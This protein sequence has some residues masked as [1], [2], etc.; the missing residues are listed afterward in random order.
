[1]RNKVLVIGAAS[2]IGAALATALIDAGHFVIMADIKCRNEHSEVHLSRSVDVCNDSEL[3]RAIRDIEANIGLMDGVIN[4]AGIQVGDNDLEHTPVADRYRMVDTNVH[5][6]L[7]VIQHTLPH[8]RKTGGF[9]FQMGD[10]ESRLT[11]PGSGVYNATQAAVAHVLQGLRNE[12]LPYGIR[13]THF[14]VGMTAS[15]FHDYRFEGNHK[16][17]EAHLIGL[18]LLRPAD[19]AQ[20]VVNIM[21]LPAAVNIDRIDVLPTYQSST[22]TKLRYPEKNGHSR[23]NWISTTQVPIAHPAEEPQEAQVE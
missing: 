22:G 1:M 5:G 2:G 11:T 6:L 4:C 15:G 3:H 10:I 21:Q 12:T 13:V 14:H 20:V 19:V 7:N 9:F 18:R 17:I 23:Q 8:L 16:A